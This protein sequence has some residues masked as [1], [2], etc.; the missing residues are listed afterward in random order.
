[1]K[2]TI[3]VD[4][5][6]C[7]NLFINY[8]LLISVAKILNLK[9]ERKR[10]ILSAFVGAL[11]S[12]IILLPELNFIFSLVIKLI[13]SASIIF[14]GFE[15]IN[16]RLFFKILMAFYGINF[17]FGG[18]IFFL[19]YFVVPN[20]IFLNNNM[21]YLNL[22]PLFLVTATFVA[23]LILRCMNK[24]VGHRNLTDL[25]CEIFVEFKGQ[26][27][28]LKAK[29]DTGNTLREPFSGLPAIV[30]QYEF[31]EEIV[32]EIIKKYFCEHDINNFLTEKVYDYLNFKDF[33]LIPYKTVSGNGLLPAFKPTYIKILS[34]N[35]NIKKEAY[36]AI[37]N[38]KIFNNEFQALVNF[39]L[40]E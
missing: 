16:F 32:P 10:L 6:I 39:E 12:L 24:F 26:S 14:L 33:R 27:L 34:Q 18:I 40:I 2:Q 37:S 11:Y 3:Y 35:Q 25:D 17:L 38:E 30:V 7:V 21:I 8:F 5:L 19:W 22:S 4:V 28:I 20:G 9:A 23:Y 29:I 13:M 1:M 36:I 15:W 31:I